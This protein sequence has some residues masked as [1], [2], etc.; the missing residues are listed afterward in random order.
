MTSTVRIDSS[1]DGLNIGESD[2]YPVVGGRHYDVGNGHVFGGVNTDNQ[3][4]Y[5]T[6][7]SGEQ[8]HVALSVSLER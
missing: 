6:L 5:S 1:I 7:N 2:F 8:Q 4:S 3:L